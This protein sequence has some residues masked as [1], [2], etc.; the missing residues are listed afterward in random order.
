VNVAI[1]I[2]VAYHAGEFLSGCT[3]HGLSSGAQLHIVS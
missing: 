2:R 1:N 3:T